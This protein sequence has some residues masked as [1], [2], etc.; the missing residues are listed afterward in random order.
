MTLAITCAVTRPILGGGDLNLHNG[1]TI[2]VV[3][4]G[5][6]R[7]TWK[8]NSQESEFFHGEVVVSSVL[9]AKER[10][11]NVRVKA[12]SMASLWTL[13]RSINA[14]FSQ[15]TYAVSGT[16]GGQAFNW[17]GCT[18][19]DIEIGDAGVLSKFELHSFQ[20]VMQISIPASPLD[21]SG[22]F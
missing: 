15:S 9:A 5:P 6:G 18:P 7:Q 17:S 13:M 8:R 1:T 14:A 10:L 11:L 2:E 22:L 16:L 21:A 19:A 3:S 12:P 20:Q 4:L